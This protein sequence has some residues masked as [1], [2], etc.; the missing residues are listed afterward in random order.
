MTVA[1]VPTARGPGTGSSACAS[2][3]RCT[4]GA[5]M[6]ATD[7]GRLANR[8]PSPRRGAVIRIV[9]ADDQEL[10]RTGFRL[11]LATEEGMEVVG[12]AHDGAHAIDVVR[13]TQ[14]DVVLMDVR[15]PV[16]DGIEAT[17]RLAGG[18]K[19][20]VLTT[21]DL[22]DVVFGAIRAGASGFVLK[23]APGRRADQGHPRGRRR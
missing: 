11:I 12:E 19:V 3:S 23:S 1:G 7:R 18:T 13:R 8:G 20:L 22:D 15:M 17:R 21:F 10:V 14:P 6:P 4:A 16:L 9:L 2:G 5:S